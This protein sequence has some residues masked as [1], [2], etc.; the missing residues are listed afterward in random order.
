MSGANGW[1]QVRRLLLVR[2]DNLGDVL[3]LGP[4]MRALRDHL[5]QAS[6]TLLASP[7]GAAAAPLLPVDEVVVW[8]ALWQDA[9]GRLPL[10]PR[11]EQELVTELSAGRFDGVVVFTSFRQTPHPPAYACYLAGIPLRLGQSKEWGGGVLTHEVPAPPDELHQV[12]R[13]LRLV[14]AIGVPVQDRSLRVEIGAEARRAA[15]ELLSDAGIRPDRPF[16]V[17]NPFTT[18]AA[19]TYPLDRTAAV[20]RELARGSGL[21]VVLTGRAADAEETA[22][23]AEAIGPHVLDLSGRTNVPQLAAVVDEASLVL[24]NNT[25]VMHLADATRTPLVV[26]FAGTE[27]ESQW[28]PRDTR[29]VLLRRPTWCSPCYRFTC[30]Y[31]L[32]CLD[33]PPHE[34]ATAARSLLEAT[35]STGEGATT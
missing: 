26:T 23:L 31:Q 19:R 11:R 4:A 2:M 30:P 9:S 21:P 27:L 22:A 20:A 32:E 24:T 10:E 15:R 13:N 6:L 28:A 12:E 8:R 33:L 25:S 18:A 17:V 29:H 3:M 7:S 16:V 34:V 14:E 1:D 5:P 35:S